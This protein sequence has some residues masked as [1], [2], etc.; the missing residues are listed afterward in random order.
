MK[1]LKKNRIKNNNSRLL[2]TELCLGRTRQFEIWCFSW[3]F[4]V[5]LILIDAGHTLR[6]LEFTKLE[7]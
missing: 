7:S 6:N 1:F 5:I 2:D 3:I 4:Q